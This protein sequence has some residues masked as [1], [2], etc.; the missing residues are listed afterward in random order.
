MPARFVNRGQMLVEPVLEFLEEVAPLVVSRM[1]AIE[2]KEW[3]VAV[4]STV[5]H[6]SAMISNPI[7]R[8]IERDE[9]AIIGLR[10]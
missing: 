9:I 4:K 2:G 3:N 1:I 7:E 6:D 8:G 10:S 5:V